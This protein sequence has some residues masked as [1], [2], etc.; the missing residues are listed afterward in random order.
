[1]DLWTSAT[2]I[3]SAEYYMWCAGM[4]DLKH[5]DVNWK[6]G[7]HNSADGDCAFLQF[8]NS[9]ANESVY[10]LGK[11][12]EKRYFVSEVSIFYILYTLY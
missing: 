11:C 12:D 1:M 3:G 2:D 8:S 9:S 6:N 5:E 10:A 7:K 4:T